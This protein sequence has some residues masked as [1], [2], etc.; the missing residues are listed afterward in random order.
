MQNVLF[1]FL[2][3]NHVAWAGFFRVRALRVW[4]SLGT[5]CD[6]GLDVLGSLSQ[7]QAHPSPSKKTLFVFLWTF[8]VRSERFQ[9]VAAEFAKE[10]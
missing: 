9:L 4:R 5:P 3:G 6:G 8:L 2:R 1:P 7:I 10:S